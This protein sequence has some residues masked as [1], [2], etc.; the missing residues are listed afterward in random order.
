MSHFFSH[1][2]LDQTECNFHVRKHGAV[3]HEHKYWK[4]KEYRPFWVMRPI[5]LIFISY[6]INYWLAWIPTPEIA[7]IQWN[8]CISLFRKSDN[9]ISVL[10]PIK[11]RCWFKGLVITLRS[12]H[13]EMH[14]YIR[15]LTHLYAMCRSLRSPDQNLLV[16]P[17]SKK[18]RGDCVF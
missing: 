11:S 9:L 7:L 4:R 6:T 18:T 17:R 5:F 2:Y 13:G 10:D 12:L 3:R 1:D 8:G 16:T 14:L 15:E